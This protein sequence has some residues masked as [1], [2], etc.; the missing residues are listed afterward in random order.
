MHAPFNR[1]CG[2]LGLALLFAAS[3]APAE[4]P[5]PDDSVTVIAKRPIKPCSEKD[6]ACIRAVAKEVWARYPKQIDLFCSRSQ[7][8]A[9]MKFMSIQAIKGDDAAVQGQGSD[10]IPSALKTVCD[11]KPTGPFE[12]S[13]P[14]WAPWTS[15]PTTADIA[16]AYPKKA[17]DV[18][19]GGDAKLNCSISPKGRLEYCMVSQEAP[20]HKGFGDAAL[21]LKTRFVASMGPDGRPPTKDGW[22]DVAIHFDNPTATAATSAQIM[23]PDWIVLPDAGKTASHYPAAALKAGVTTGVGRVDCGIGEDGGLNSCK[24]VAEDPPGLGF[25][26]AALAVAPDMHANLWSRDGLRTPGAHVVVPLR[27][28]ASPSAQKTGG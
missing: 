20:D 16:A 26:D 10:E 4:P 9:L 2:V 22:I 23:H 5:P 18:A 27:F 11:Y 3:A 17:L 25:G 13:V 12:R 8:G 21:G 1:L 15:V 19:T 6:D 14:T 28:N 24:V 7:M